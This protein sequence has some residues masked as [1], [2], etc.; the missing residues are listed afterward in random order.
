MVIRVIAE[1]PNIILGYSDAP[2]E[3]TTDLLQK[4]AAR[5]V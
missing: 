2:I 4:D 1:P 3:R 5:K